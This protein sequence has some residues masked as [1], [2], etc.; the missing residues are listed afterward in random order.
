MYRRVL[1]RNFG[2]QVDM[3]YVDVDDPQMHRYPDVLRRIRDNELYLPV[4][5]VNGDIRYD[6]AIPLRYLIQDLKNMGMV[7]R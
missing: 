7:L 1:Q 2:D 3:V 6:G 4:V 5:A